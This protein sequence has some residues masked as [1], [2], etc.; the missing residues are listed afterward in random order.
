[1]DDIRIWLFWT[2][3]QVRN[4]KEFTIP[5]NL[6]RHE[7][8]LTRINGQP[9][10][11]NGRSDHGL[12]WSPRIVQLAT[13]DQRGDSCTYSCRQRQRSLEGKKLSGWNVHFPP[14]IKLAVTGRT[15]PFSNC[16]DTATK[17][18]SKIVEEDS[19]WIISKYWTRIQDQRIL[20]RFSFIKILTKNRII[21]VT[22]CRKRDRMIILFIP[23]RVFQREEKTQQET[24]R[25]EKFHCA[26]RARK[27]EA[28]TFQN[29]V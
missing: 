19:L 12:R 4:G 8:Q 25:G 1:M 29:L 2:F 26:W 27:K 3:N 21:Q 10:W 5:K 18:V 14:T 6:P 16:D 9:L 17:L 23:S 28:E 13:S 7:H 22:F 15:I 11:A 20:T 24:G